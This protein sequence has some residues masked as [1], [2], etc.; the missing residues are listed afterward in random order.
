M[1]HQWIRNVRLNICLAGAAGH[2]GRELT[3][4]IL[5]SKDLALASAVGRAELEFPHP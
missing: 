1:H 3:K 2:V 4:A 5:D